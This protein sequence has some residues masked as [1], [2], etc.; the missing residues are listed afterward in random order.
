MRPLLRALRAWA[1]RKEKLILLAMAT[2]VIGTVLF[3]AFSHEVLEGE[4][5]ALDEW[6]VGALRH[7]QDAARPR[8]P[9][10]LVGAVRD[11]TALG[12]IAVIGLFSLVALGFAAFRG[13]LRLTMLVLGATLGGFLVNTALKELVDRPRPRLP[14]V[15]GIQSRSFPSGH[16]MVSAAIYLSLAAVL[17]TREKRRVI[18]A[19]LLSVGTLLTVLVGLSRV[20]LGYHYPSDVLAGW[21]AG[22]VW[23]VFC[24]LAT[25][26][27]LGIRP[28]PAPKS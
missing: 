11:I 22:L 1:V 13:N 8:G 4:T 23:A 26:A 25:R 15:A 24:A 18:K 28:A 5:Q 7:R 10:W 2:V 14:H 9:D 6:A 17:A 27:V 19:Y 21:L 20:Y 16:A 12:S 3:F